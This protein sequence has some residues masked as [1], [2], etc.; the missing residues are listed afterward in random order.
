[1]N[2]IGSDFV[3][4]TVK[5]VCNCSEC[6]KTLSPGDTALVSIKKGKVRKRICSEE[7]RLEF[8]ARFWQAAALKRK[9][10]K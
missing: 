9:R 8:D 2:L 10:K 6:G 7:C 1:M 3:P 5:Y 4:Q